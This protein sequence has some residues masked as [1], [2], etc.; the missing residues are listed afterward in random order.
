MKNKILILSL[1]CLLCIPGCTKNNKAEYVDE[2][3]ALYKGKATD[4]I[5][6]RFYSEMPNVPYVDVST[7]FK[8]FYFLDLD[9]GISTDKVTYSYFANGVTMLEVDIKNDLFTISDIDDICNLD[10]FALNSFYLDHYVDYIDEAKARTFD[11]SEYGI[12]L[13][14]D[15]NDAYLPLNTLNNIFSWIFGYSVSYNG[16]DVYVIN[17]SAEI[18][19]NSAISDYSSYYKILKK[20][21]TFANDEAEFNYKE[22][23]FTVEQ[24]L[25]HPESMNIGRDELESKGLDAV[26]DDYPTLKQALKSTTVDE[27][28]A[29][30]YL[31]HSILMYDGG[32]AGAAY[33]GVTKYNNSILNADSL[34]KEKSNYASNNMYN[35]YGTYMNVIN[36]RSDVL[37]KGNNFYNYTN[38]ETMYIGFPGFYT[39]YEGWADYYNGTGSIPTSSDSY[40]YIYSCLKTAKTNGIKNVVLDIASNGGGDVTALE[41]I[42][43]FFSDEEI[44]ISFENTLQQVHKK[45]VTHVDRNLD[46]KL[47]DSDFDV[48]F[49]FNFAILTS[50]YSFSCGNGLPTFAKDLG[51]M[52]IGEQS[53]GG[54]CCVSYYNDLY[55]I[56][57]RVS[58]IWK[59]VNK[60]LVEKDKGVEVDANLILTEGDYSN[61]YNVSYVQSLIEDF[62]A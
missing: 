18:Y 43:S 35:K 51:V 16:Q 37:N 36:A 32:H 23:C 60:D 44:N 13:K 7:Y 48:S 52:I 40:A 21:K 39:D 42:L 41:G 15:E 29:G 20:K 54:S 25:G 62:Y 58:G 46:G 19:D 61:F 50:G 17:D 28:L 59:L 11:L 14:G 6:L 34:L 56:P 24:L 57:Y 30:Q 53:G 2:V 33:S 49:D 55:G 9:K 45:Q 27:Y 22:L 31:F 5:T 1:T 4:E 26:L 3:R 12:D 38:D 10:G 47:D 8:Q